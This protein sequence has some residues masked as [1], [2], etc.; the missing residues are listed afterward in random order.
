MTG[1]EASRANKDY[2]TVFKTSQPSFKT[3]KLVLKLFGK[4]L[5]CSLY[6]KKLHVEG[7]QFTSVKVMCEKT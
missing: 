2:C 6:T 1:L 3:S 4:I 7:I 5:H